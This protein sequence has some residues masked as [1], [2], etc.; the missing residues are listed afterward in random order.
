MTITQERREVSS[1]DEVQ[2]DMSGDIFLKQGDTEELIIEADSDLLP[3]MKSEVNVGR[4]ELGLEHWYDFMFLIPNPTVRYYITMK[5]I[6]GIFIAGSGKLETE[7]IHTDRIRLK[8]SGSGEF[9][10]AD[11]QAADLEINFSGSGKANLAGSVKR[12]ELDVSGSGEYRAEDLDS[13]ETRVRISGSASARIRVQQRLEVSISGSGEVRY[14]GQ[15]EI[16]HR[17]SG[18]GSIRAF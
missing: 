8:I 12:Q 5:N 6:R 15:P 18:S 9:H 11:L 10:I 16:E 1:F 14:H 17:I 7:R 4:L 3:R 2:V 13:L